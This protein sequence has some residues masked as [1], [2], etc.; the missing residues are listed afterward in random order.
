MFAGAGP[1]RVRR[2]R[3]RGLSLWG[4]PSNSRQGA[5][6]AQA[7]ADGKEPQLVAM[8]QDPKGRCAQVGPGERGVWCL[9][10]PGPQAV[11]GFRRYQS[12]DIEETCGDHV[13]NGPKNFWLSLYV[14]G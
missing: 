8:S 12:S 9:D 1:E 2:D 13:I 4:L 14:L 5:A 6:G 10:S 7:P 3:R 11:R